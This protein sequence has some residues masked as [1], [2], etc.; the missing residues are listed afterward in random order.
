MNDFYRGEIIQV[1]E[2]PFADSKVYYAQRFVTIFNGL[3]F[4]ERDDGVKN[5]LIGWRYA[6]KDDK[7]HTINEASDAIYRKNGL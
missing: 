5:R 7:N 2:E 3:Y 4:C 1:S 6:R